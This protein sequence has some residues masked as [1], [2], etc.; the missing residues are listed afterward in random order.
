MFLGGPISILNLSLGTVAG[1]LGLLSIACLCF[2]LMRRDSPSIAQ[3]AFVSIAMFF[4][5]IALLIPL[6]RMTPA[7]VASF[8][9]VAPIPSRYT[10]PAILFWLTLCGAVF[11]AIGS[12]RVDR[13]LQITAAVAI[14]VLIIACVRLE[15][16][17]AADWL[18]FCRKLDAAEGGFIVNAY[19]AEH[20][21]GSYPDTALLRHWVPYLRSHGLSVFQEPRAHLRGTIASPTPTACVATVEAT[22]PL[23][24][25]HW[26]VTGHIQGPAI[27]YPKRTDVV[28]LNRLNQVVG[29]GRTAP[30]SFR[31]EQKQPFF[32]YVEEG[33]AKSSLP[34]LK[35][36]CL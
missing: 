33:A 2:L 16:G 21:S 30:E 5:I 24:A 29:I 17:F 26:R 7:F 15:D 14:T 27:G 12:R 10:T 3:T 36:G 6:T 22:T 23:D 28:L 9:G 20:V 25:N 8:H 32:A 18:K 4:A 31:T 13:V 11:A 34:T 35:A 1:I 19:D